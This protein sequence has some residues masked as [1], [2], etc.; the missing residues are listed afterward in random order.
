MLHCHARI[1]DPVKLPLLYMLS[2]A[3]CVAGA[4]DLLPSIARAWRKLLA[5]RFS[6]LTI[7][8]ARRRL[9]SLTHPLYVEV[10]RRSLLRLESLGSSERGLASL[11][12]EEEQ[13]PWRRLMLEQDSQ[14][15]ASKGV[16]EDA[17]NGTR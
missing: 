6:C 10:R 4:G 15:R 14:A 2:S 11:I 7:Y 3:R 1:Y 8:A 5:V 16:E 17:E 12:F 13:L 9:L